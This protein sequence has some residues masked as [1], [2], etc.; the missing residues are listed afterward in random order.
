[1]KKNKKGFTLIE[2]LIVIGIITILASAVIVA[3]NPGK[4]FRQARNATRWSH[5]N[6]IVSA[7]YS[8]VVDEGGAFP[9]CVGATPVNITT[10]TELVPDYISSMPE[11]PQ[12]GQSY[13]ISL[14]D[15]RILI[16]STAPE[17]IAAEVK[18]LQ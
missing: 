16:T 14:D 10:C 18:V 3:I 11:D 17:A 5:M 13:M 1:M 2:L 12:E 6:S 8:Y 7:V 9:A 4:H 15:T